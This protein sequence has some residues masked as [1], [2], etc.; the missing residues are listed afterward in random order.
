MRNLG[1]SG[2][3][4][5]AIVIWNPQVQRDGMAVPRS[6]WGLPTPVD[7]GL[8]VIEVTAPGKR[9]QRIEVSPSAPLV[10]DADLGL[11]FSAPF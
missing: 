5:R 9:A 6:L 7:P 8:H 1:H 10:T 3:L 11:D 4:R 2:R